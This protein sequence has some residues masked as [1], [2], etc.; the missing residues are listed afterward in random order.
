M[1]ILDDLMNF[2]SFWTLWFWIAHVIAWSMASH[3]TLGVPFDIVQEADREAGE[4]GPWVHAAEAMIHA[5]AFRFASYGRRFG[6]LM[7]GVS[8]FIIS[9]C[10]T[11]S[12]LA[13]LELARALLTFFVPLTLV[14]IVTMR[15][16][17][18]VEA[19]GLTGAALRKKLRMQ[20][21]VNQLIGLLAIAMAV[22]FAIY[23]AVR[24]IEIWG[25]S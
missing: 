21:L 19:D 22:M 23:Q 10:I 20:R 7:T 1:E 15:F 9:V 12:I 13:D 16:A 4:D 24:D 2:S 14:Y 6:P 17:R 8:A 18:R 3:F 5:Q 11:L 25:Y